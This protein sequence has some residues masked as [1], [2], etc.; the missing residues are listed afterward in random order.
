VFQPQP[1]PAIDVRLRALTAHPLTEATIEA[2]RHDARAGLVALQA[3]IE[4]RVRLHKL[5]ATVHTEHHDDRL[6]L[7]E[8]VVF[9]PGVDTR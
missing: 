9:L 1:G 4:A 2:Q 3:T 8:I 5:V 6:G 7:V